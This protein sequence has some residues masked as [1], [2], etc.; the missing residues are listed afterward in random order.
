MKSIKYFLA[1]SLGLLTLLGCTPQQA[2]LKPQVSGLPFTEVTRPPEGKGGLYVF[3]PLFSNYLSKETPAFS[4]GNN[5]T[6]YLPFGS[7]TYI[8]L[9]SGRYSLSITQ[10]IGTSDMWN[11]NHK[12]NIQ[13]G[14][15]T[16]VAVWASRNVSQSLSMWILP[17]GGVVPVTSYE[18]SDQ[19]VIIETVSE[20]IAI[21]ALSE[22]VQ[23]D[24]KHTN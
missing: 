1:V 15:N 16:Y 14:E 22:C 4:I 8:A 18:S 12:V 9:P 23:R 2:V 24:P 17:T 11:K 3:R 5:Q 20:D 7:Y 10:G 13:S 6:Y 19:A 21:P